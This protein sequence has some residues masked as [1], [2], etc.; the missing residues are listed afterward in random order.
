MTKK[1]IDEGDVFT[2]ESLE[3]L[4]DQLNYIVYTNT[5]AK[6]SGE[7]RITDKQKDSYIHN[8]RYIF[9]FSNDG[10]DSKEM[11]PL[12]FDTLFQLA[13]SESGFLDLQSLESA[14]HK[15]VDYYKKISIEKLLPLGMVANNIENPN[16]IELSELAKKSHYFTQVVKY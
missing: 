5:V 2:S 4:F 11:S 10:N 6:E 13:V 9:K 16:L 3:G 14:I 12:D 1:N 15:T 8:L 7:S